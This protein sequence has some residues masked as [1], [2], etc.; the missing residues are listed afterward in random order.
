MRAADGPEA[1]RLLALDYEILESTYKSVFAKLEDA[2][3]ASA[4][5]SEQRGEQFVIVD[6]AGL[7]APVVPNRLAI[8]GLGALAGFVL[9]GMTVAGLGRRQRRALA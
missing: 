5:E 6:A 1:A 3:M 9:G 8:A 4:L 2:Q 7:G